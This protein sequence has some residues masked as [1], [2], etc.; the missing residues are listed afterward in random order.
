MTY[1]WTFDP[2]DGAPSGVVYRVSIDGERFSAW[3][4]VRDLVADTDLAFGALEWAAE[5]A[6][7]SDEAGL[8][9]V[10]AVARALDL[11]SEEDDGDLATTVI[12]D[13]SADGAPI[14]TV[15]ASLDWSEPDAEDGD[16]NATAS[17]LAFTA[18]PSL[19][20][21]AAA[22]LADLAREAAAQVAA[23]RSRP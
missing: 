8:L 17:P 6:P 19:P 13:V 20:G 12:V 21:A 2:S 7:E 11:G 22:V 15:R 4:P 5:S 3:R 23:A 9:L 14:M 18:S 10:E 16:R 1:P